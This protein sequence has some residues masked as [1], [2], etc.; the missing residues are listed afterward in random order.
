MSIFDRFKKH[1]RTMADAGTTSAELVESQQSSV[2]AIRVRDDSGEP[3]IAY[4]LY[5]GESAEQAANSDETLLSRFAPPSSPS[6][7]SLEWG[8][9]GYQ[10]PHIDPHTWP[11]GKWTGLPLSHAVTL[12]LPTMYQRR[13]P[14]FPGI[15]Y[16]MYEGQVSRK[17]EPVDEDDPFAADVRASFDHPHVEYKTD[18]IGQVF[19][20]IWLTEEELTGGRT[21]PPPDSRRP[22]EH[23]A[24]DQGENAWEVPEWK[25]RKA[26]SVAELH[27]L[28]WVYLAKRLNDP[29]AGLAPVETGYDSLGC[30]RDDMGWTDDHLGGTTFAGAGIEFPQGM[31]PYYLELATPTWDCDYGN[32]ETHLIDLES[33][34]FEIC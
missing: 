34:V 32:R 1:P 6:F 33:D 7:G 29:N 26:A 9:M 8:W 13:G 31:T 27:P 20:L 2:E 4:D 28:R 5:F 19:A 30:G 11:R 15:A 25:K 3:L 12:R 14:E 16:F 24:T 21:D 10:G 17:W 22:G 23:V 18:I